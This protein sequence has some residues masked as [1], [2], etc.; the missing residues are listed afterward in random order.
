MDVAEAIE[1]RLNEY[2]IPCR[3][4]YSSITEDENISSIISFFPGCGEKS[5]DGRLKGDGIMVSHKRIRESLRRVD[6][7]GVEA[8]VRNVLHRRKYSPNDLWHIDG[9][10]KL[11]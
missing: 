4:Q 2:S 8:H 3:H 1:R 7:F 5:V 10:H 11:I 6:P 9:Y